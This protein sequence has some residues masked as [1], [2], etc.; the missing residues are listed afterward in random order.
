M[1][2]GLSIHQA[3]QSKELVNLLNAASHC[4]SYD[5]I[6][7]MNTS[8]A[9]KMILNA[10]SMSQYQQIKIDAWIQK[11]YCYCGRRWPAA[12]INFNQ[13]IHQIQVLT[14]PLCHAQAI[15][16]S[17]PNNEWGKNSMG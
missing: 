4:V 17:L 9:T 11:S 7:R 14:K 5:M 3:T 1:E 15:F 2:L 8:I 12:Y 10:M 13:N 6:R 16:Y